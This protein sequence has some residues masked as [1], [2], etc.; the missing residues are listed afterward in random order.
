M[1]DGAGDFNFDAEDEGWAALKA[2]GFFALF[3]PPVTTTVGDISLYDNI[4]LDPKRTGQNFVRRGHIA[5]DK[6][7]YPD[8]ALPF[9]AC[10]IAIQRGG[11][12][13]CRMLATRSA[14][15]DPSGL[16]W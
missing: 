6:E 5:F 14:T 16:S 12:R 11:A 3:H 7:W 4:W 2:L 15:T 8:K 9:F 13:R 1:I 10:A